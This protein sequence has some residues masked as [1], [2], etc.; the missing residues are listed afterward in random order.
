ML[1]LQKSDVFYWTNLK[2]FPWLSAP[3]PLVSCCNTLNVSFLKSRFCA[4]KVSTVMYHMIYESV[5]VNTR[6]TQEGPICPRGR[7]ETLKTK[8]KELYNADRLSLEFLFFNLS[9]LKSCGFRDKCLFC[10]WSLDVVSVRTEPGDHR[11]RYQQSSV[12]FS[13]TFL[14]LR[15]GSARS[16]WMKL[17]KR[18]EAQKTELFDATISNRNVMIVRWKSAIWI[19]VL[20]WN[21]PIPTC[22]SAH[23]A[24]VRMKWRL[25]AAA[26][27]V[28][29]M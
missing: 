10:S 29:W 11:L 15:L 27:E 26:T 3:P 4:E 1:N 24:V 6:R 25:C 16:V 20:G 12:R 17:F 13:A 7:S 22:S 21:E 14:S 2:Y 9:Y 19:S 28:F 5:C 18:N 23:S 8:P